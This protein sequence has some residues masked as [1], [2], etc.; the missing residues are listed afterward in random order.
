MAKQ[1]KMDLQ[2]LIEVQWNMHERLNAIEAS[3]FDFAI[4][5]RAMEE[6]MTLRK[7]MKP[8]DFNATCQRMIDEIKEMQT[9]A[10]PV[11]RDAPNDAAAGDADGGPAVVDAPSVVARGDDADPV[12]L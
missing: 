5:Q 4:R 2:R 7:L 1:R 3:V 10:E 12:S 9:D 8:E 11:G 6:L